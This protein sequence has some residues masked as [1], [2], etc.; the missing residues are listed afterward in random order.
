MPSRDLA[1]SRSRLAPI[2]WR[3]PRTK[4]TVPKG[5]APCGCVRAANRRE[6]D[7]AHV[8]RLWNAATASL[9]GRWSVNGSIDQRYHGNLNIRREG[10]DA[11]R[12]IADL[13]DIA[14]S[15]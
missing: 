14:L 3:C 4:S 5:S 12:L 9:A 8:E 6:A 15:L 10:V 13:R 1:A 11:A 2:W 7:H